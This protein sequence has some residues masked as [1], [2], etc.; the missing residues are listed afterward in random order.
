MIASA[1]AELK[2]EDYYRF[3]LDAEHIRRLESGDALALRTPLAGPPKLAMSFCKKWRKNS[4]VPRQVQQAFERELETPMIMP[5]KAGTPI[6]YHC[7]EC[8]SEHCR[9]SQPCSQRRR[10]LAF[11]PENSARRKGRNDKNHDQIPEFSILL[12]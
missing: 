10:V 2:G 6:F 11:E 4:R 12:L 9:A 7:A 5:P 8:R 1:S 3:D